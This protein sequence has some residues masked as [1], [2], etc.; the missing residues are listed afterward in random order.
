MLYQVAAPV[1]SPLKPHAHPLTMSSN[2]STAFPFPPPLYLSTL[3]SLIH[4]SSPVATGLMPSQ[5]SSGPWALHSPSLSPLTLKSYGKNSDSN[6]NE[7]SLSSS[8]PSTPLKKR[9][10]NSVSLFNNVHHHNNNTTKSAKEDAPG[11]CP[12]NKFRMLPKK[13]QNF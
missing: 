2:S 7:L 12:R 11:N 5:M 4:N 6:N 3:N 9:S 13:P 10:D 1:A 8:L